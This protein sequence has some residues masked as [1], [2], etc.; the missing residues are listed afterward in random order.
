VE[1][2]NRRFLSIRPIVYKYL[3]MSKRP[4]M[5]SNHD[6]V[7]QSLLWRV[8]GHEPMRPVMTCK[9]VLLMFRSSKSAFALPVLCAASASTSGELSLVAT[10]SF[11]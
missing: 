1:V 7:I 5:D 6:K 2:K 11:A 9:M 4:R 3:I 10:G 8:S